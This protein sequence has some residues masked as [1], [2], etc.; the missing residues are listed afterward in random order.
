MIAILFK[1]STQAWYSCIVLF[2]P[3]IVVVLGKHYL[4]TEGTCVLMN[5]GPDNLEK[6]VF[7]KELHMQV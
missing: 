5:M 6:H 3:D 1:M 4:L 7:G 2:A